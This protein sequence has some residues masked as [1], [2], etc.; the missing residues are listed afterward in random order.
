MKVYRTIGEVPLREGPRA[1]VP[2]MGAFHEGHLSLM[3]RAKQETGTCWVSLFVNPTQFAA[4][5]D[6]SKYPRDEERDFQMAAE[7]GAEAIF[8]PSVEVMYAGTETTISVGGVSARWEGELRPT[9]FA[10]VATVVAKLFHIIDPTVAYFGEKDF[11]QCAVIAKMVRDL[12]FPVLLEFCE[13]IREQDGLA[14]SSRNL[15]LVPPYR[16]KAPLLYQ[17]LLRTRERIRAGE[18]ATTVLREESHALNDQG[19]ECQ[20]LALVNAQ[21]LEPQLHTEN[22]RLIVAAKL[23]S[24]RLIDNIRA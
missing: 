4:H 10:G 17:A 13:T 24:T 21:T 20:Y 8:A 3:R 23:G 6:L 2:T 15:Y 1:L 7:A 22:G 14:M 19:F 12:N 11:Q 5:E 16:N 9:H 18:D